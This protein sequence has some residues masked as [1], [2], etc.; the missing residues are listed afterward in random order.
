MTRTDHRR[1]RPPT[2][3]TTAAADPTWSDL[4]RAGAVAALG[5]ILLGILAPALTRGS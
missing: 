2:S 1:S 3:R 4:F 5:Y